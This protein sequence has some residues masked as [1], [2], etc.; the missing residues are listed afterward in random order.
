V[1]R[2]PLIAQKIRDEWGTRENPAPLDPDAQKAACERV[3][4]V[5]AHMPTN[6]LGLPPA[7]A[8]MVVQGVGVAY[9]TPI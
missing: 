7:T 6:R 8:G 3:Q 4:A 5:P 1:P 2:L 9:G